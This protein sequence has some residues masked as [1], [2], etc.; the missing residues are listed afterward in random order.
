MSRYLVAAREPHFTVA[1]G[2]D[3]GLETF[4]GTVYDNRI[5]GEDKV[6]HWVGASLR[7]ILTVSDLANSLKDYADLLPETR[8]KLSQDFSAR[9]RR[10]RAPKL[11]KLLEFLSDTEDK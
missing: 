4:F 11:T 2:W 9:D 8:A 3:N 7:E 5:K 6:C 1:V 10:S